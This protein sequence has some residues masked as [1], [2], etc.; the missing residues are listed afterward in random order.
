MIK[1]KKTRTTV[2]QTELA[3]DIETTGFL[4]YEGDEIFSFSTTDTQGNTNVYRLDGK[5]GSNPTKNK[6]ILQDLFNDTS[7]VKIAHNAKF[8]LSFLRATGY[9][10]PEETI[11][12]DTMIMS[13][14]LDNLAQS[15][16]LDNLAWKHFKYPK[17]QDEAI[18]KQISAYRAKRKKD[19]PSNCRL[20]MSGYQAVDPVLMNAYQIADTERCM[21][22][23]LRFWKELASDQRMWEDYLH[24]IEL[25]KTTVRMEEYGILTDTRQVSKL[26]SFMSRELEVAQ[27]KV[28]HYNGGPLNVNSPKQMGEFVYTKMGNKCTEFTAKGEPSVSKDVLMHLRETANHP[29]Y[30]QL[31]KVRAYEKGTST[32]ESYL[33]IMHP[34]THRMHP[35]LNTN[36]ARTGRQSCSNPNLQNVSKEFSER[37]IFG[38]PARKCFRCDPGHVLFL[39]DYAGIELRLIVDAC[40]EEEFIEGINTG[41]DVHD[42]AAEELY[43]DNWR[44]VDLL[45]KSPEG[46]KVP[47]WILAIPPQDY[48]HSYKNLRKNLRGGAKNYEFGIS[49]GGAYDA[50]TAGLVGLTPKQKKEG[51]A[52]FCKRWPK[53]ANFTQDLINQVKRTGYVTTAFGRKLYVD[54]RKAYTAANYLIQ[55]TAA[56]VLKRGQTRIDAYSRNELDHAVRL[57]VTVH[58]EAIF[59]YPKV[60]LPRKHEILPH[61][62]HLMTYHPEIKVKLEVEADMTS[63][64]WADAKV[65]HL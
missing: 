35:N 21:L 45:S 7:I 59:S 42:M 10:V 24:E 49:Y 46:V 41:V 56:G 39:V 18:K 64:N 38:V 14:M 9:H 12:H 40:N 65:F 27:R 15:H 33:E 16:A 44:E 22:L 5:D 3:F 50:I 1:R 31:L 28:D 58:D 30:E 51:H 52:N 63:T 20:H 25:I 34:T 47:D 57:A 29:V 32:L 48:G 61:I 11:W 2:Q 23:Y 4:K 8:E 55:G 54:P 62:Y 19:D 26:M 6:K 37:T 43:G 17:D 60:L 13:Q 36:H 53:I